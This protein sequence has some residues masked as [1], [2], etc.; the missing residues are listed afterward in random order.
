MPPSPAASS[1]DGKKG[2][3]TWQG[4]VDGRVISLCQDG[5]RLSFTGCSE[6]FLISYLHLDCACDAIVSGFCGDPPISPMPYAASVV[7]A[8]SG[9]IH[10]SVLSRI[11]VPRMRTSRSSPG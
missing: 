7:C 6:A 11:Y 10:G 3:D 9:R 5:V 8:S 1:S 2:G 4:V